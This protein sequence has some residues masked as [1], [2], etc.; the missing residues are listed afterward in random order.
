MNDEDKQ[1]KR[2]ADVNEN[3]KRWAKNHPEQHWAMVRKWEQ[4]N[5][6][7]LR[8]IRRQTRAKHRGELRQKAIGAL[9]GVCMYCQCN[10]MRCLQIDHIVPI[11]GKRVA[12]TSLY[13]SILRGEV[14]NLQL[15]CA[16]CHAIKTYENG[17]SR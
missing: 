1:A 7:R 5:P 15:L 14:G 3:V 2:R 9:G 13:C 17:E 11:R 10:D 8:E 12:N 4:E 16:N 6:E